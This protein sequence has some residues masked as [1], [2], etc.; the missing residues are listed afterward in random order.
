MVNACAFEVHAKTDL[1]QARRLQAARLKLLQFVAIRPWLL[2][3]I[4]QW[5]ASRKQPQLSLIV[6]QY[7][8]RG[9]LSDMM[10]DDVI[11]FLEA[12]NVLVRV[13]DHLMAGENS[14]LLATL[15]KAAIEDDLFVGERIVLQEIKSIMITNK[16]LEGW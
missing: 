11:A 15:H 5:S 16:M 3:A 13:G 6:S 12:R 7:L 10:H 1:T 14:E 4:R 8:R 2:P 9:F